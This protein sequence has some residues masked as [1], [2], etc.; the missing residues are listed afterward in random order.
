MLSFVK[1]FNFDDFHCFIPK[2][3]LTTTNN[4]LYATQNT[5]YATHNTLPP[6]AL[7]PQPSPS[8]L[9]PPP[10][11]PHHTLKIKATGAWG[12]R[13]WRRVGG[14]R[15]IGSQVKDAGAAFNELFNVTT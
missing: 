1:C 11:L 10:P 3:L 6:P 5:L 2:I 14:I 9:S 15:D 13:W 12:V 7:L 4:A 8:S